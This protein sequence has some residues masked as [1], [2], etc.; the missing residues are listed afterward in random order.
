M[1][2]ETALGPA[3]RPFCRK[4]RV[5]IVR[6]IGDAFVKGHGDIGIEGHLDIHGHFRRQEFLRAVE[7]A[8]EG[9]AFFFYLPHLPQAEHLKA[10]AV[11]EDGLFPV[12]EF[13]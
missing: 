13:V 11:R 2:V 1:M 10:A 4:L 3:A 7:V 8:A 5:I 12:H 6:R 9:Y